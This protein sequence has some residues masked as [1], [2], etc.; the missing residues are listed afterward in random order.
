MKYPAVN[1]SIRCASVVPGSSLFL[2]PLKMPSCLSSARAAARLTS[3][4][5]AAPN[6]ALPEQMADVIVFLASDAAA[7]VNGAIV[8]ADGGWSAG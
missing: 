5:S 4:I 3:I 7:F 2:S 1:I 6:I 8:A